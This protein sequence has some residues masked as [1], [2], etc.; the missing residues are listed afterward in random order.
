MKRRTSST[1]VAFFFFPHIC[2]TKIMFNLRK[3]KCYQSNIPPAGEANAQAVLQ[4][5]SNYKISTCIKF[6][7]LKTS[8]YYLQFLQLDA[9]DTYYSF[10]YSSP[11]SQASVNIGGSNGKEN[12][13]HSGIS[14]TQDLYNF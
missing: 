9:D 11:S 7:F 2:I 4:I 12:C 8:S 6:S 5:N 3:S 1:N 13:K 10:Q 14:S